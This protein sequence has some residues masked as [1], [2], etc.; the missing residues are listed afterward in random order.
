MKWTVVGFLSA[1]IFGA[2]YGES[3]YTHGWQFGIVTAVIGGALGWG[4]DS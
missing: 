2:L 3:V 4:A 1:G